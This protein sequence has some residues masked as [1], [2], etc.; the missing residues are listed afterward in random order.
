M[1]DTLQ[2]EVD[3]VEGPSLR[4]FPLLSRLTTTR[5]FHLKCGLRRSQILQG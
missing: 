5:L 1:P 4:V 2:F 3:A